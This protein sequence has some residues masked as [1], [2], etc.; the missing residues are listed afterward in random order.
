MCLTKNLDINELKNPDEKFD[1]LFDAKSQKP[2]EKINGGTYWSEKT[3]VIFTDSYNPLSHSY[4]RLPNGKLDEIQLQLH[5]SK[6]LA[7]MLVDRNYDK[8]TTPLSLQTNK[9]YFIDVL[10]T[11]QWSTPE[12]NDF[13]IKQRQCHLET[14]I[15]KNSIFKIYTQNNCKICYLYS[16]K[17]CSS[18]AGIQAGQ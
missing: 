7:H 6:E 18:S 2:V 1:I 8:F 14:E 9:E 5:Q 17:Y 4:R 12:F 13:D 3:L 11:G 10:P 15:E 16:L